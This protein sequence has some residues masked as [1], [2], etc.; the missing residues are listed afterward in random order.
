[1]G[2]QYVPQSGNLVCLNFTPQAGHEQSGK[3]PA[4]VLSPLEY[5]KKV[6][7]IICCPITNQSKGYQFEVLIPSG[8]KISGVILADQVK[9]LDWKIRS[10]E[11]IDKLP[12]EVLN[13]VLQKFGTLI[14]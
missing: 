10:C 3:L 6:G 4:V 7:L 11:F 13:G 12:D 2:K 9:S 1:M 14:S 5:N 8:V